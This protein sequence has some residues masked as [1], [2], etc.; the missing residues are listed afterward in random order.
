MPLNHNI[1]QLIQTKLPLKQNQIENIITLLEDGSTIAFI[2]RYRKDLTENAS[3]ET[4]LKFQ[5]HYEYFTKLLKRK[6][7][8]IHILKERDSLSPLIQEQLNNALTLTSLEDIY[9]PFKGTKNTKADE[10]IKNGLT[11]LANIIS[12]MKYSLEEIDEKAKRFLNKNVQTIKD[13]ISGSQDIIALRYSQEL[14]TKDLIRKNIANHGLLVTKPTKTFEENGLYKDL[15][16]ISQK[17]NNLK[18]YRLLAIF[19]AT[20]ENQITFK[21]EVDEDYLIDGIKKFRLKDHHNSSKELVFEAYKDG[22]KRLLLPSLKREFISHLKE[23]ASSEAIE[24]FGKNLTELLIAPPLINQ[25]ILGI[26]PGYINGCKCAIIDKDGQY[27]DSFII[28]LL[29]ANQLQ[30]S[31]KTL[32]EIIKKYT[33]TAIAIGNGT[34]SKETADFIAN[35]LKENNLLI[36]YAVVSEIGASVYSASKIASEEYPNLDVTLRG[37][38]SIAAR[39]RDP[40]SALVKIDPKS[41]GVG[42]YQHDVNQNELEK[43]LNDT[44]TTLV[45]KVGVDINSASYKLLSYVSGIGEKLAKNICIYRDSIGGFKT[46]TELQKVKGLGAK[47]YEQSIGFMRIK[48]GKSYLDNTGIHPESYKIANYIKENFELDSIS[49]E[50]IET[51]TTKFSVGK[52]TLTDIITE[53]Q[54]PGYDIREELEQISFCQEIKEFDQLEEGDKVDGVVRNITDFGAFVDIGLKND[55]LLHIS[56]ISNN[57]INHPMD[58][59]SVN[60]QLRDIQIISIDKDKKRIGLSLKG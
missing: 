59:L 57:R 4:L 29:N 54:K 18:S 60:Q 25:V 46:K 39:L 36:N 56:Q 35:L 26:D 3:D 15:A 9:E 32:I 50:D 30:N 53:L 23:K 28:Y 2:A 41:L 19:R 27:L 6:E 51:L 21:I 14:N 40:M 34:A 22:L 13:A 45:N 44:T 20:N 12:T 43:K 16:N 5:D 24:L 37:A 8:I 31:S 47:A 49:K 55:A 38:I 7:E 10:A 11:D 17:A 33:V 1:I 58:I 52:V 48:D 42:Q